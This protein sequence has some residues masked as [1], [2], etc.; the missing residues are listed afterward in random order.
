M[1]KKRSYALRGLVAAAAVA[2]GSLGSLG[3][4]AP[5]AHASS[6][7]P[8]TS[9]L[10]FWAYNN[11]TG[12]YQIRGTGLVV[13]E[14]WGVADNTLNNTRNMTFRYESSN[15]FTT[16]WKL[17]TMVPGFETV[18]LVAGGGTMRA[19]T[20]CQQISFDGRTAHTT[21]CYSVH[22]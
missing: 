4:S 10:D 5:G 2:L 21:A 7:V 17:V 15:G 9:P 20:Y 8:F 11:V 19:G 22:A 13:D 16:V 14:F 3:L 1:A 12:E 6:V 18:S